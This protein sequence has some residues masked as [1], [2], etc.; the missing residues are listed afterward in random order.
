MLTPT[1][2]LEIGELGYTVLES[3]LSR[4]MLQALRDRVDQLFE[5]EGAAAG[6]EFKIEE[7]ARR[8]A[9][10]VDKGT[11]F[12]EMLLLP[13]LLEGTGQ[14]LGDRYKLSSLNARSTNPHSADAQ[15][16]HCDMGAL[17]D[18]GGFWVSNTVWMLDDFTRENGAIRAVPGTH[19]SGKLPQQVLEDARASHPGEVLITAP[20]GTIVIMNA[21]CW[22]G[23]TANRT[24]RP[25]RAL[26]SF[27]CRW[28]KPQQQWQKKLLRPETQERLNPQLRAL[29]ALD[30][31]E[32]DR[33]S[34]QDVVRSGFMK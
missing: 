15:P 12:E 27:F 17:P 34:S 3:Y 6:S 33:L 28:D 11:V 13:E 20:A 5:E 19:R 22:H 2:K 7:G 25:R 26:H 18:E 9:N 32:N 21:H 31:E 10:L 23:G 24:D 16:L 30:D 8:L 1:Q 29:L 14:V 4:E